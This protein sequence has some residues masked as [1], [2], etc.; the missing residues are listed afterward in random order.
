MS[1]ISK[2]KLWNILTTKEEKEPS[3]FQW[4]YKQKMTQR[5]WLKGYQQWKKKNADD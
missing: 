2:K 5:Q 4:L 1:R 3:I